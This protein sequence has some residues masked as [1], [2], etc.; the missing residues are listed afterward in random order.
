MPTAKVELS[1]EVES[2]A[3]RLWDLLADVKAW[4]EWQGTSFVGPPAN[5]RSLPLCKPGPS[6]SW[7]CAR[8]QSS[9]TSDYRIFPPRS[10][11]QGAGARKLRTSLRI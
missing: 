5:S 7:A 3:E 2:T 11:S 8:S 1:T 9:P 6:T 10:G 4:P